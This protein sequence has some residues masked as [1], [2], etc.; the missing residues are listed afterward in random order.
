MTQTEQTQL[1]E[2]LLWAE[3]NNS[4]SKRLYD[5]LQTIFNLLIYFHDSV[6][7]NPSPMNKDLGDAFDKV[8]DFI[9]DREE[10]YDKDLLH[11]NE[12][13]NYLD[14]SEITDV[15]LLLE[16]LADKE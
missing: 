8:T 16:Q 2:V 10:L 1:R 7:Y 15:D 12:K 14:D 4:F 5:E 11:Y 13:H 6:L 9:C 3:S